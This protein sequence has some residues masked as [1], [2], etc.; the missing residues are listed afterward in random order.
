MFQT[1]LIMAQDKIHCR[2]NKKEDCRVLFGSTLRQLMDQVQ[3]K[4]G[5]PLDFFGFFVF[6]ITLCLPVYEN[7]KHVQGWN[8]TTTNVLP[9][10]H[11]NNNNN[12]N[13]EKPNLNLGKRGCGGGIPTLNMFIIFMNRKT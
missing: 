9:G 13:R 6:L 5:N 12:R 11:N 10:I 2:H 8:P 4:T 3:P 1:D 7:H